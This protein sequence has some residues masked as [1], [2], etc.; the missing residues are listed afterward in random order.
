MP[1][2]VAWQ[3]LDVSPHYE[4]ST[5]LPVEW[6]PWVLSLGVTR[7]QCDAGHSSQS[8]AQLKNEWSYTSVLLV[9]LHSMHSDIYLFWNLILNSSKICSTALRC[10]MHKHRHIGEAILIGWECIYEHVFMCILNKASNAFRNLLLHCRVKGTNAVNK[11]HSSGSF[12][13]TGSSSYLRLPWMGYG[14]SCKLFIYPK[15]P[16]IQQYIR[17]NREQLYF[18][19]RFRIHSMMLKRSK[20]SWDL[21]YSWRKASTLHSSGMWP[22]VPW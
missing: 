22:H 18:I 3:F 12:Y 14:T 10:Y 11:H 4:R 17:H 2:G 8:S 5:K 19:H 20:N 1:A 21:R 13:G 6:V 9:C 7:L 16:R 15:I